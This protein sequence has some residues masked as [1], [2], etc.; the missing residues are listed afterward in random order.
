MG[1]TPWFSE[2]SRFLDH[3]NVS[4]QE[5]LLSLIAQQI[6]V[7]SRLL[8]CFCSQVAKCNHDAEMLPKVLLG[9]SAPNAMVWRTRAD[10]QNVLWSFHSYSLCTQKLPSA[11]KGVLCR[12]IYDGV[13]IYIELGPLNK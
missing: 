3:E 8:P 2:Q 11:R 5:H 9:L 7:F 6:P 10:S 12:L 13:D 1:T 4:R